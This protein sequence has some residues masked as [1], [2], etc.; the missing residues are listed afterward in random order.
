MNELG[1]KLK[2]LRGKRTLR[3]LARLSGIQYHT[4]YRAERGLSVKFSTL[5]AIAKMLSVTEEDWVSLIISWI[6][7]EV[8]DDIKLVRLSP[9]RQLGTLDQIIE[10]LLS[11]PKPDQEEILQ[12][13]ER[14]EILEI[15]RA[16]NKLYHRLA[17]EFDGK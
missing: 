6:K 10:K 9:K 14:P 1:A 11:I 4:Y 3:G 16:G 5:K 7:A 2:K 17:E 15:I 13:L 12:A 8:G